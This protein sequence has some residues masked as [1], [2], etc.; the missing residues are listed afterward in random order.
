M[1]LT[2]VY[3][4]ASINKHLGFGKSVVQRL[5]KTSVKKNLYYEIKERVIEEHRDD[6][7]IDK[8]N[9]LCKVYGLN[10]TKD[11]RARL[12]EILDERVYYHKDKF[13]AP[14]LHAEMCKLEV[15]KSGKVEHADNYHDDNIFSYLMAL[16]VWYDGHNLMENF[17]IHK[18]TIKTDD[19][20]DY[21]EFED[22]IESDIKR[23]NIDI[24]SNELDEDDIILAEQL[25]YIED[26][27][28]YKL[29]YMY[30]NELYMQEQQELDLKMKSDPV[31]REAYSKKYNAPVGDTGIRTFITI[32]QDVFLD[33]DYQEEKERNKNGNLSNIFNLL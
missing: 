27:S 7:R 10:S 5:K 18:T 24:Q 26:A 30:N 16:Y 14:I 4:V 25:K 22:G 11:I 20:E 2:I 31:F 8:I 12:I 19:N 3:R 28:R 1:E 17:G 23:N 33:D 13:I 6:N 21:E 29:G 15:K 9:K 32:P